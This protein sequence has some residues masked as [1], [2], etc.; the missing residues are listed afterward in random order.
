MPVRQFFAVMNI[1]ISNIVLVQKV[2]LHSE[3]SGSFIVI[4]AN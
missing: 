2:L 3:I 4:N 1:S